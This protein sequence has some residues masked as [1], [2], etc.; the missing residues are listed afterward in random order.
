MVLQSTPLSAATAPNV[1]VGG[2]VDQ[3][4]GTPSPASGDAGTSK[5]H[6]WVGAFAEVQKQLDDLRREVAE[7]RSSLG[8][9]MG[10][11]QPQVEAPRG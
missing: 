7:L 3:P 8:G 11:T 2:S 1:R 6:G 10:L 9:H 4:R 5:A